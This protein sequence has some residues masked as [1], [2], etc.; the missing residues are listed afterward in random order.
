MKINNPIKTLLMLLLIAVSV[1]AADSDTGAFAKMFGKDFNI[2]GGSFKYLPNKKAA[3]IR[4]Y[5]TITIKGR[6]MRA[7]NMVYFTDLGRIYAEGDV[8]LDDN[9]GTYL[10]CDQLYIDTKDWKGRALN[11]RMR[12]SYDKPNDISP[13]EENNVTRYRPNL[14]ASRKGPTDELTE[15]KDPNKMRMNITADEVRMITKNHMEGTGVVASPSNYARPHWGVYS[16]AV[17]IR[18]DEKVE[19]FHNIVKIGKV[20]VFYLP[21]FVY[22]L[23]YEWP[24]YRTAV[25]SDNRKGWYWLNRIGWKF[26]NPKE[27]DKGNEIKRFFQLDDIFVDADLAGTD[28]GWG[29][30]AETNYQLQ[31][32]GDGGAGHLRGYWINENYIGKFEDERRANEDNQFPGNEWDGRPGYEKALYRNKNRGMAEWWHTQNL[33][34]R[35][36]LRMQ[37]H[38]F[39]DRDFYKEYF[40]NEWSKGEDKH[41]N[42]TLRYIADQFQT[43]LIAQGRVN[44]FESQAEYL[45]EWRF[46]M[47]GVKLGKLPIYIENNTRF[48][49][50]RRSSDEMLSKLDLIKPSYRTGK[51]GYTPW[52]GRLHNETD[53][54]LPID[55][56][57]VNI[58]PH[59]GGFITGYTNTYAGDFRDTNKA[60]LNAAG[61]WG[62]DISSRYFGYFDKHRH[63]IEPTINITGREAP[64]LD[65]TKLYEIDEVDNYRETHFTKFGLYQQ[66][67]TK[68]DDGGT[69]QLANLDI[70]MGLIMSQNEADE[71]NAGSLLSD[72]TVAGAVYPIESVSIFGDLVYSPA[73]NVL[74]SYRV[75]AD[76]WYNSKFRVF[77][78]H[79]YDSGYDN[80]NNFTYNS[81]NLTTLALRSQLWNKHSHYSVE[82]AISYQWNDDAGGYYAPDGLIRGGIKSGLQ[83]QRVSII[84]DLDTFE[85]SVN[86]NINHL[87]NSGSQVF[88]NLTPKGWLGVDRLDN[89]P[90]NAKLDSDYGRY[91][92]PVPEKM[93]KDDEAYN[94]DTPAWN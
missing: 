73:G 63:M 30:G 75:G 8:L 31:G 94:A 25:G 65:R 40:R 57:V 81:S 86:W 17:H 19:A 89:A 11:I 23:R 39:S 78:N 76:Y 29:F 49:F 21:Y 48:G 43:E 87:N 88:V 60:D 36:D 44:N 62:V 34:D 33:T 64:V 77:L 47:P 10:N 92:H 20:P 37:A 68:T 67:D 45:P 26:D 12:N 80:V 41:T 59:G 3:L 7:R 93:L 56:G 27:D 91:S 66:L 22:D 28:R 69:R 85:L 42:A 58:T 54:S 84:R 82:Y 4:D 61:F 74:D 90:T 51:G 6:T 14:H 9:K 52:L 16:K 70:N 5:A 18:R 35:L 46:N 50:M 15:I 13:V 79:A 83:N 38:Y 71:Y 2:D 32:V 55:L 72:V 53:V 1:N 24:Y